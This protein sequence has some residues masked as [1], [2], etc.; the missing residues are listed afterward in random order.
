M[1]KGTRKSNLEFLKKV[2]E[3]ALFVAKYLNWN[4][5][6]CSNNNEMKSIEEIHLEVSKVIKKIK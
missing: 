6:E 3:S 4:I 5:I 2:Y 1:K